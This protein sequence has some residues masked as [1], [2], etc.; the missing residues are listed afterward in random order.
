MRFLLGLSLLL[1]LSVSTNRT[2]SVRIA[3]IEAVEGCVRLAV[4]TNEADFQNKENAVFDRTI[5][6]RSRADIS[7]DIP[8]REGETYGIA[9]FHDVNDNG[10]LDKTMVGIPKEPYAFS[11]NPKAKWE[12]P[13]FAD[14]SFQPEQTGGS[15]L[16]LRLLSWGDR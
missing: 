8:L 14:I 5:P 1:L 13:S 12:K 10:K 15:P 3:N 7:L 6:L 2:I 16:E 4:F 9:L 11:N